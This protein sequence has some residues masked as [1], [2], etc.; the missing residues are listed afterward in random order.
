MFDTGRDVWL[1]AM[2]ALVTGCG[3][4]AKSER[5]PDSEPALTPLL[6]SDREP[7]I[8]FREQFPANLV[9]DAQGVYWNVYGTLRYLAP[10]ASAAVA[11]VEGQPSITGV[12][13][14]EDAIYFCGATEGDSA[15]LFKVRRDGSD[16][17]MLAGGLSMGRLWE[18]RAPAL[19]SE[20]VYYPGAN[21]YVASVP[22]GGGTP[23]Q[24][25]IPLAAATQLVVDA[26]D[27]YWLE[28]ADERGSL[29]KLSKF[30]GG[31][32]VLA[33]GFGVA[34][35]LTLQ[36][37]SLLFSSGRGL[38]RVQKSGG[39]PEAVLWL[40]PD[41]HVGSFGIASDVIYVQHWFGFDPGTTTILRVSLSGDSAAE[42]TQT[43]VTAPGAG[44]GVA[45][46]DGRVLWP[47]WDAV[48]GLE[49]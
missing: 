11:L 49:L 7:T 24:T 35:G 48:R 4:E 43:A 46:H 27:F 45:F 29:K 6:S 33:S 30:G 9:S 28:V 39:C 5:C 1:G 42:F 34:H 17:T 40:A 13:V 32:M 36:G 20:R 16:L 38:F 44:P 31:A 25:N 23:A 10:G 26:S 3:G 2:F 21:G 37:D 15:A 41:H 8:L 18:F 22:K 12:A 14:D 47:T 19:D